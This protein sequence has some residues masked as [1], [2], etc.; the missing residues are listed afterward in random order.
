MQLMAQALGVQL[1]AGWLRN[2]GHRRQQQQGIQTSRKVGLAALHVEAAAAATAK[3]STRQALQQQAAS[4]AAASAG[5]VPPQQHEA[6]SW[7]LAAGLQLRQLLQQSC[8]KLSRLPQSHLQQSRGAAGA[9]C[10]WMSCLEA[11]YMWEAW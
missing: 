10:S 9:G 2:A 5:A 6:A 11:P 4:A 3:A 8:L 1:P 7:Q